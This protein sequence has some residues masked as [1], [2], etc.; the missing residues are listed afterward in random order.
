VRPLLP[1]ALVGLHAAVDGGSRREAAG[2]LAVAA[3]GEAIAQALAAARPVA[4]QLAEEMRHDGRV[5]GRL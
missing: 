4:E 2:R 1:A 5:H 3:A